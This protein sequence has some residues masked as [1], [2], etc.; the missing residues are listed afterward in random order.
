M[1]LA[2]SFNNHQQN[3]S[4]YICS[5][6]LNDLKVKYTKSHLRNLLDRHLNS[7]SLLALKD[8]LS[9]YGIKSGA[10][11]K[12]E[13]SYLDFELPFI[14]SIQQEDWPVPVFTIV[15]N[16]HEDGVEYL[17]PVTKKNTISTLDKFES[18]EKGVIML[19]DS[20]GRINENNFKENVIKERNENFLANLPWA[21]A[22][23]S[24]FY[25]VGYIIAHYDPNYSWGNLGYL[26][27]TCI[28]VSI[29][30]LLVWNEID[31]DNKLIKQVCGKGRKKVNCNAVLSSS[32]SS[33]FDISWSIWGASYF[34]MLFLVQLLFVNNFSFLQVTAALSFLAVPYVFYSIYVQWRIIKQWC[35]LCLGIQ[36]IL[37]IN[38]LIAWGIFQHSI[39]NYKYLDVFSDY[40]LFITLF[41]GMFMFF[42]IKILIPV[43][44]MAKDGKIYEKKLKL[45]KSNKEV[46]NYFLND[47]IP[48]MLSPNNL[49]IILGN[50][51]ASNEI[52]K[53]CNPYCPP[54]SDMHFKLESIIKQNRDV[55]L[56]IIF[57][58]T[59]EEDDFTNA[60]VAYFLAV[61]EAFGPTVVNVVLD[62]W[63]ASDKDYITFAS[64]KPI[65]KELESQK[66]K[67]IAMGQW[68][69]KMKVRG[70]PSLFVNGYELPEEYRISD[71]QAIF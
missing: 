12:G 61:Q 60:P 10:I 39:P 29:S 3:N 69:D 66:D 11:K 52:I 8:T 4:F 9:A 18:I 41:I 34:S 15:N 51:Y 1:K 59:G 49:G 58:A 33:F 25:C 48:V 65:G 28:A 57:T 23:I 37:I 30:L 35:L 38:A 71:L 13:Y 17:D 24:L 64:K 20:S 31:K 46:F 67:I 55:K 26:L 70:T 45:I 42:A 47:S 22:I 63:Y 5:H 50:P 32:H 53:V 21:L 19:L 27:T 6:L 62:D 16:V 56:R 68:C 7:L 14:C 43:F 40:P 36:S 54:C 2:F 44:N